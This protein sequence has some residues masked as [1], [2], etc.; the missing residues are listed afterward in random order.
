MIQCHHSASQD[1]AVEIGLS[2]FQPWP[3]SPTEINLTCTIAKSASFSEQLDALSRA[4]DTALAEVGADRSSAV[5]R[6]LFCSDP[7]NQIDDLRASDLMGH[8]ECAVSLVGQAPVGPG[9]VALWAYH[10]ID[11]A[12][13]LVRS[14][15]GSTFAL[16]RD[17][18][19]HYW[20]TGLTD[21]DADDAY[22][23]SK[24]LL[25]TYV[26]ELESRGLSLAEHLMRTWFFVRDVDVNYQG[27]VKARRELFEAH[28][29]TAETH[30]TASSGIGGDAPDTRALVLLDAWAIS[31]IQPQQVRYLKALDHLSPTSLYGVTFERGTAIRYRDRS[32]LV[33][34]GTASIDAQGR[35]L[36]LGDVG[37]QLDRTLENVEVLLAEGGATTSDMGHWLVYLRDDSDESRV[38]ACMRERFGATPMIF[39]RAPVCRPGWLVE[40]E[41]IATIPHDA[42]HLPAF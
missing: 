40:V 42:P 6:R 19:V 23:Q 2:V 35:I 12:G 31:G 1:A 24:R 33:I 27:L 11:P 5:F 32:H 28:G 14:R 8:D 3:G 30:Y 17:P 36:H 21:I 29:L 13:Q 4:Y 9:K 25:K 15:E 39:V 10:L 20:T 26:D 38:R 37:K 22:S 7:A 41:G 34:S 18:L 16:R